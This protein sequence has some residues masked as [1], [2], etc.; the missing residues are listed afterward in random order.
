MKKDYAPH[1]AG[2]IKVKIKVTS[3]SN[4]GDTRLYNLARVGYVNTR[5]IY[6][7]LNVSYLNPNDQSK[8]L[9]QKKE[10][11]HFELSSQSGQRWTGP[12][13]N[14]GRCQRYI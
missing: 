3:T 7:F 8:V 5:A 4:S 9:F 6:Y 12:I 10:L 11:H 1:R 13:Q 14:R 2:K